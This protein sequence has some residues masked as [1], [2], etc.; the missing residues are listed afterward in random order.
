M[1]KITKKCILFF[2]LVLLFLATFIEGDTHPA[3]KPGEIL[4]KLKKGNRG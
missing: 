2:V 4:V 1:N 3:Y